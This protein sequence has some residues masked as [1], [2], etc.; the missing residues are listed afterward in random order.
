M[1]TLA[2]PGLLIGEILNKKHLFWVIL[3]QPVL[4][5]LTLEALKKNIPRSTDLGQNDPRVFMGSRH[6]GPS[7]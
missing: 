7:I 4:L 6:K 1:Q 3:T 5:V 2:K